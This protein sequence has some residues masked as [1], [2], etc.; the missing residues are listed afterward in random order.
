MRL[1]VVVQYQ[2]QVAEAEEH[3]FEQVALLDPDGSDSI[4]GPIQELTIATRLHTSITNAW[5]VV[6]PKPGD[7][8]LKVR[9]AASAEGPW[10]DVRSRLVLVEQAPHPLMPPQP[11]I[12]G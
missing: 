6:L 1:H 8:I 11:V 9:R 10:C 3:F 7:Y 5:N 4:H 2:R 12:K